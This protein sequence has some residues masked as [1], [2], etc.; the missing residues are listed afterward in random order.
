MSTY[1]T[2]RALAIVCGV[3]ATGGAIAL[4]TADALGS[5]HWSQDH[6]IAPLV[7]GL[8]VAAGHLASTALRRGKLLAAF[9]FAIAF[10]VGTAVTVLGGIGRQSAQVEATMAEAEA[11]NK[12]IADKAAELSK[13][14]LR[15]DDANA[16]AEKE[17]TGQRC[18]HRCNDWKLRAREVQAHIEKLET[19]LAR[20]GAVRPV[21]AKA[22]KVGE[23]ASALGLDGKRA[24]ALVLLLEPLLIPF[25]LEWT[26][27]VALGY[28]LGHGPQLPPAANEAAPAAPGPAPKR[29]SPVPPKGTGRRGRKA[30]PKVVDFATRFREKH[31]KSPGGADL[32]AAFPGMPKSTAYD[33]AKRV[34]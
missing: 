26:A 2:G 18:G 17:M 21:N 8:T 15:L 28:G 10:A 7:V 24:A 20:L 19:G 31:G 34:A 32:M 33:Y 9:G 12:A 1:H 4:L 6:A 27:I 11:H 13:A 5:G 22:E 16:A 30:D 29:P 14:R 25:L 23:I 3:A